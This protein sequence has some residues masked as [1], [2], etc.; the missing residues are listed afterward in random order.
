M[1]SET[2]V[3]PAIPHFDGHY[4][5]W[6]MLMENFLKSKEYWDVVSSGVAEPD[7]GVVLTAAQRTALDALKLK[8]LKAKNY[9]FQA[10][11]RS[12]LETILCK[13]TSKEIWDS[14][15]KKYQGSA[16]AKRQQL[17]TFRSEFEMLRMK[18]GETITDFF[19]RTMAIVNKMRIHGDKTKDVIIVEKILRSLTPKFNF[20]VCSIEEAKDIEELYI[21]ELQGSLLVH[22]QKLLQQETEEQAL[23]VS[24]GDHSTSAAR[25]NKGRGRG[26]E[27][28]DRSGF[29]F[30]QKSESYSYRDFRGRGRGRGGRHSTGFRPRSADKSKVECF[31]C[32]RYGHYKSECRTNLNKQRVERTNFAEKEE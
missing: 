11:N 26:R 6:S 19:S 29:S 9:L 31:R 14:M 18:S 10:I 12:I 8:D 4:D 23:K 20:I 15:K 24:T 17:Q 7:E 27:N 21:D 3:Q 16:R 1:A 30:D 2:F 5:H 22:E 32:H 28:N 25:V 13:D